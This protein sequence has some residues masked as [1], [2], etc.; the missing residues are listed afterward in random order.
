MALYLAQELINNA[1]V[2]LI[3]N[4]GSNALLPR[5][6]LSDDQSLLQ[7]SLKKRKHASGSTRQHSNGI[8][9]ERTVISIK[10]ATPLSVKIAALEA[11]EALLTAV[12]LSTLVDYIAYT[13]F[14]ITSLIDYEHIA[15]IRK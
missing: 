15:A 13:C 6:H 9:R 12:C 8:D 5:K 1:F 3:D 4:P 11:L 2:D 14:T 10:P 7:S